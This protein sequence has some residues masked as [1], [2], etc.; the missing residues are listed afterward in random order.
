MWITEFGYAS[1]D[2]FPTGV[3]AG[4]EWM[5]YT[6]KLEQGIYTMRA[7]EIIQSSPDLGV[8]SLWNLNFAT[9]TGLIQNSDERVAYSMIVPGTL[10]VIDPN[11]A[12]RTERPIYWML[13]DA[14]R[15]DVQLPSF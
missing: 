10:G 11:S 8:T 6:D 3:P 13:Y 12:D 14:V 9:L 1:W 2:G 15:P 4:D 5:T 7:L